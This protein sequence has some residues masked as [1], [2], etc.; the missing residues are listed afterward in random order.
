M[1]DKLKPNI[2]I[3]S[4]IGVVLIAA[5]AVALP[6]AQE[7][8]LVAAGGLV[9]GFVSIMKELVA[10]SGPPEKTV[11]ESTV[12]PVVETIADLARPDAE[13]HADTGA[14]EHRANGI[15]APGTPDG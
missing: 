2:L 6:D 15:R 7:S 8:V 4:A 11:P 12:I 1:R 14:T 5:M 13:A 3:L 10:P 9:A